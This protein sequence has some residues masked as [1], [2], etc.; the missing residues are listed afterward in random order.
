MRIVCIGSFA[1]VLA[2]VGH[3]RAFGGEISTTGFMNARPLHQFDA[4]IAAMA[5]GEIDDAQSG[6]ELIAVDSK[7]VVWQLNPPSGGIGEWP[8]VA[9]PIAVE[10]ALYNSK[11]TLSIGDALPD[12]PGNE[13]VIETLNTVNLLARNALGQWEKQVVFDGGKFIGTTWGARLGEIDPARPGVELL[14]IHEGILDFSTGQFALP[15]ASPGGEWQKQIVYEGEVGMDSAIGDTNPALSGNEIIIPTEMGPVYEVSPQPGNPGIWPRR[16]LFD[17]FENAPYAL[18]I[19]DI[20]PDE[21]GN[22]I[23]YGTRYTASVSMSR[24]TP[25]G[26]VMQVL[27]TAEYKFQM[28]M[29]DIAA[30]NVMSASPALEIV[31]VD[32]VGRAHLVQYDGQSWSGQPIWQDTGTLHAALVA[33]VLPLRP[34]DEI[35]VTGQSGTITIITPQVLG[36]VTGNGVVDV[37]D[38]L[39]VINVWGTCEPGEPCPADIAPIG[40]NGVVD[41]D[42]LLMVINNW[43]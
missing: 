39:T 3:Q 38:L 6:P 31:G 41:V 13:I 32:E 21:P 24:E 37:D 7:G 22:E 33:D 35:L 20:L 26:H 34:G 8:A 11:P 27:Y 18:Q 15:P 30:G 2:A 1:L 42:D 12:S 9:L 25:G 28:A 23:V 5:L 14:F 43:S 10:A 36:D 40:G 17:D 19:G 4:P 16:T 29:Y